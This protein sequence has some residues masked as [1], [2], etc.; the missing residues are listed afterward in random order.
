[1]LKIIASITAGLVLSACAMPGGA[2]RAGFVRVDPAAAGWNA[3]A[4]EAL[5]RYVGSQK[6]TGLIIAQDKQVI[7]EKRWP[8][9]ADAEGFRATFVHGTSS[10]G[11]LLED[12]ASLQKSFVAILAG[13]A[14][15]KGLLDLSKPVSSYVGAGWSR[16]MP[17]QEAAISV[18]NLLEMNSGLKEDLSVDAPP[19]AKF[20]YNTPAYVIIKPVLEAAARQSLDDLTQAWLAQPASMR[21]TAWRKRP[22]QL[23][24]SGNPTGLVTTTRDIARMGQLVLN[25]GVTTEGARVISRQQLDALFVRT[26]TNPSY[27]RLWWL[28]GGPETVGVG[29]HSPRRAGQFVPAAPTDMVAATGALD[30]KLFIVPSRKLI[31][32]RTGQ[33]APDPDVNERLWRLL[34][35]AL[36]AG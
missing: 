1:M 25:G 34:A 31:V 27:G 10:D 28:N 12:V 20:F 33:A 14:I 5:I 13:I 9:S 16:A 15:D 26:R 36:P 30:R 22:I 24:D 11:A 7:V 19:D 6:S 18:R 17:Q 35:L 3:L 29:L 2:S 4:L 23:A 21:D 8:L 32:V